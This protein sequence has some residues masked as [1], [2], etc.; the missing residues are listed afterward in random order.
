MTADVRL[1]AEAARQRAVA[2]ARALA[3]EQSAVRIEYAAEHD[4]LTGLPNRRLFDKRLAQLAEDPTVSALA[5]L[6]LD[7]DEFKQINDGY[8]HSA[9]DAVLRAAALRLRRGS[10]RQRRGSY[11]RRRIR[12]H[13]GQFH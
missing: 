9:G 2:E 5:V 12:H 10:Q 4:Y 7:L 8:G 11:R 1:N 13:P 3:L 6:H